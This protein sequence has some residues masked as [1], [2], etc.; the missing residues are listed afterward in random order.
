[1]I[2]PRSKHRWI[3]VALWSLGGVMAASCS[4]GDAVTPKCDPTLEP[5]EPGA[6]HDKAACDDGHGIVLATDECCNDAAQRV[7]RRCLGDSGATLD[8][9]NCTPGGSCDGLCDAAE[10]EAEACCAL[11]ICLRGELNGTGVGGGGGAGGGMGGAGAS[12][13]MGG[14]GVGGAAGAGGN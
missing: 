4:L 2:R 13:G 14:A 7:Y 6:C 9:S 3:L 11:E 5:G 12:A 1:M 10:A 8:L